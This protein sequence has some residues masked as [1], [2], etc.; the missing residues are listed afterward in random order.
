M[1]RSH[2]A[3]VSLVLATFG[4]SEREAETRSIE[5]RPEPVVV[6]ASYEDKSYLPSLFANFTYETGIRVT[7]KIAAPEDIVRHVTENSGSPPFGS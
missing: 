2:I 7:V 4:C 1:S 3:A 6:Y 5:P